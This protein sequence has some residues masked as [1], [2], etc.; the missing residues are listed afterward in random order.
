M[1]T[2][3]KLALIASIIF[4]GI[5]VSDGV[6]MWCVLVLLIGA[7][8]CIYYVAQEHPKTTYVKKVVDNKERVYKQIMW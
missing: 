1:L 2:T 7:V 5:A 4:T 8:F 3:T 6:P